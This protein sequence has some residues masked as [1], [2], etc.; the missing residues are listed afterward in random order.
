MLKIQYAWMRRPVVDYKDTCYSMRTRQSVNRSN[1]FD[2]DSL[3]IYFSSFIFFIQSLFRY[4]SH[5]LSG[6]YILRTSYHSVYAAR[7]SHVDSLMRCRHPVYLL[8]AR[9]VIFIFFSVCER[10]KWRNWEINTNKFANARR[11]KGE[12]KKQEKMKC[13]ERSCARRT[14][15]M[16]WR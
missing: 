3:N 4:S 15:S 10:A 7:L 6:V 12:R 1:T 5:S 8:L 2:F 11:K 14:H 9:E 16:T 13:T